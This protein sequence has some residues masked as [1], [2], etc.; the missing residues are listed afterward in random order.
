MKNNQSI[1]RATIALY[2]QHMRRRKMQ[3]TAIFA[4]STIGMLADQFVAPLLIAKAFD[5]LANNPEVITSL[6]SNFGGTLILYAILLVITNV[7]WRI[8]LWILWSFEVEIKRELM[9]RCFNFLASQSYRFHA[10]RFGGAL[11]SQTNKFVNAFER[12]FDEFS[13]GMWTN[14]VAFVATAVI[15]APRAPLYVASFLA[16]STVYIAI[17]IA[18]TR[19]KQVYDVRE[20]SAEST[21]TA[22]LADAITNVQTIKTFAHEDLEAQLFANKTADVARK[23]YDNRRITILNDTMFSSLNHSLNWLAFFFGLYMVIEKQAPIGVF[24]LIATYTLNLLARLWQLNRMMRNLTRGFGDA[25]DMT[26]I[27]Q[28]EPE[29][30]D[31]QN[32]GQLSSVRGDIRFENITFAYPEQPDNPLFQNFSLHIKPGEKVGLVGH[33]GSGKT[34]LTKL[35]LRF[36]DIQSGQILIDNQNI[37]EIS[38]TSLRRSVAYVP[39]E[40]LMFHRSIHDNIA[41]GRLDASKREIMIASK[42][43]NADEFVQSLPKGYDTLVG[44]RGTKLSGGQRQRIA[45]ARAMLKNAPILLL[46]E[47]TS[48]LDSESEALI[49]DALWK[50]MEG[51]TAIVIAHRLSTIQ[52]MDRIIVM[53]NGTVAE[54]GT[55]KEL[56]RQNGIYASLWAH[57]SGG[58]IDE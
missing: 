53:D 38:Q 26:E 39:Q 42:L 12:L 6:W 13:F 22:Q 51:R 50:L 2:W 11:V 32:A 27:L 20:A 30:K 28:S 25:H 41:Y 52:K 10:N 35:I 7:F 49:Q 15:L 58:F 4:T 57:Q 40:P 21:Q 3:M 36:M 55:H 23:S 24:Y 17:L 37:A 44:E 19:R 14:I 45:I 54:Q 29:I 56:I 9:T 48:A 33:S 1:H 34:S 43:A 31:I 18:R 47:A 8:S 5:S 46:D 16:V